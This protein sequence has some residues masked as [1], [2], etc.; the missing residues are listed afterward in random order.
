MGLSNFPDSDTSVAGNHSGN[1]GNQCQ[2]P[3][4]SL[5]VEVPL[6][7]TGF[8]SFTFLNS[9]VKVYFLQGL[10]VIDILNSFLNFL[11]VFSSNRDGSSEIMDWWHDIQ[12][13]GGGSRPTGGPATANQMI[14]GVGAETKPCANRLENKRYLITEPLCF[15]YCSTKYLGL[16]VK[17]THLIILREE[18]FS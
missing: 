13:V 16:P 17:E 5:S 10:V 14:G 9:L 7:A 11:E 1:I 4:L 6:V 18:F 3:D 15:T 2:I 8:P 12:W